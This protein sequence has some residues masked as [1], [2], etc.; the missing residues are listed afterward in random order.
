MR[1][2]D[3]EPA[4]EVLDTRLTAFARM[5]SCSWMRLYACHY[6][7]DQRLV[8]VC[9][10]K[11]S[12]I[13]SGSSGSSVTKPE[14][15]FCSICD[16]SNR[17][18]GFVSDVRARRKS[19]MRAGWKAEETGVI[20]GCIKSLWELCTRCIIQKVLEVSSGYC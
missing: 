2:E 12:T 6:A 11:L 18:M 5:R 19:R 15:V 14:P 8:R 13:S 1:C 10:A 4:S 17:M 9:S 3:T 20:C 16:L 7:Q